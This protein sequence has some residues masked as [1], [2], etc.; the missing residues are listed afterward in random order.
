[1]PPAAQLAGLAATVLAML[2]LPGMPF[3]LVWAA[4]ADGSW[5]VNRGVFFSPSRFAW[6][7]LL[8]APFLWLRLYGRIWL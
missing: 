8:P 7:A 1:M 5:D 3:L 6:R 2:A 4:G